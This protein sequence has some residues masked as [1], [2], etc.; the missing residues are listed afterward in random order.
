MAE[1]DGAQTQNVR[2][3]FTTRE[4][5]LELSETAPVLI[6]TTFRRYQLSQYINSQLDLGQPVPFEI[7][8]N[9]SYL[10]TT[11]D[12]YLTQS[13]IS[14]EN[15]LTVE[16][17]RARIP[18]R[19]VASYEHDDWVSDV[20]VAP[21]P[22]K[23]RILTASYDGRIR[24]W[25]TSSQVLATSGAAADGGH[26]SFVKS[27]K[28]VS[29]TQIVSASY[30]RTVKL[31]SYREAEDASSA[32]LTPTLDLYGHQAAVEAVT[33]HAQSHR[34]LTASM[35]HSVGF[36]STRKS[37][38]PAA[39]ENLVPKAIAKDGKRR[40]LNPS[41]SAPQRGPLSLMRAHTAPVS[42]VNFDHK[43]QTVGYSSSLDHTVRTWDLVTGSLVDT[44]TTNNALFCLDQMPALSLLAAGSA[45][46]DV[47]LVDP[48]ASAATVVAMMLRGHKNHVV[49]LARDPNN[50]YVLA[51]G[52]HDGTC[53]IWDVRSTKS[54]K[55]G[56]TGQ[57]LFTVTRQSLEG[58]P[59]PLT[60]EGIKVFGICW[61][62]QIGLLTAGEDKAVQVNSS[63]SIT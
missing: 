19:Y 26:A 31:W 57:S 16:Y 4:G 51:S 45:S 46:R 42:D 14:A 30:D 24:V 38:A 61:D 55:D 13:G 1:V 3:R 21:S 5:D 9:G 49:S 29:G 36:W 28:F 23:P 62:S 20:H 59:T 54:S 18:P 17:V 11:L 48:R 22:D 44:R 56:V 43:D 39:P 27:A 53:R 60:G 10:R 52:S 32:Q 7:L 6:P 37:D 2:L 41:I 58:K 33:A 8:I 12:D 35:D 40:K 50:D 47:K 25:N 34:L 63:E 15:V